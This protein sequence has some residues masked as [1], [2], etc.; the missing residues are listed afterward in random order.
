M[1]KAEIVIIGAGVVGASVA[2][3]LTERG[4]KNV[5]ILER[6]AAQ[7]KGSTGKATGGVRAQFGT[8]INILM[9][10]YSIDF[11]SKFN[12]LTGVDCGYEPR[13]YMFFATDEK[14][15]GYLKRNVELQ[16]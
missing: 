14:Q 15:L 13:G 16:K 4:A 6:E 5:L 3:H 2:Y 12:E 9:S 11:F 8:K 10:L 1:K 7:G